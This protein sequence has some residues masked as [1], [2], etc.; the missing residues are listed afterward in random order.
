[1]NVSL[2]KKQSSAPDRKFWAIRWNAEQKGGKRSSRMFQSFFAKPELF[3]TYGYNGK[4]DVKRF[5]AVNENDQVFCYQIDE[6]AFRGLCEVKVIEEDSCVGIGGR[7]LVLAKVCDLNV[8][9]AFA[10]K[11]TIVKLS[12]SEA[13]ALFELCGL[14]W[15]R[16]ILAGV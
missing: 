13:K 6:E 8:N 12:P 9:M 15:P 2:Y 4:N 1:M 7:C 3:E 10:K 14:E 11:G 16:T 5:E